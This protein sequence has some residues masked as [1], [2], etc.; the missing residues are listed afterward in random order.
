MKFINLVFKNPSLIMKNSANCYSLCLFVRAD[1]LAG[2]GLY[3]LSAHRL[4]REWF[5]ALRR[6]STLEFEV[7]IECFRHILFVV[8]Q[9]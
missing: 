7:V 9:V 4:Q 8:L 6:L 1:F 3:Q 5:P 2:V